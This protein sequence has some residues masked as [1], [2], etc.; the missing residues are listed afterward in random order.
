MTRDVSGTSD[1]TGGLGQ[2]TRWAPSF[3]IRVAGFAAAVAAAALLIISIDTS[4][5]NRQAQ[6][7]QEF[8]AIKAE[9]FYLAANFRVGLRQIRATWLDFYFTGDPSDREA[10][11]REALRLQQ[12]LRS[13]ER[14][15]LAPGEQGKF[16]RLEAAYGEFMARL[17]R[18]MQKSGPKPGREGFAAA[19]EQLRVESQSLLKLCD[20][21]V[22]TE[23][24][25][26]N[27]FLGDSDRT[28]VSL[29]RLLML[30]LLLL[31]ASAVSL[32][33]VAYRGM[34]A[35]LRAQLDES[36]AIIERQEKLASLGTLGAGVAHEIRNPLQ[37]IKFRLFSLKNSLPSAFGDNEDARVITQEIDRLDRIVKDFLQFARPSEPDLVRVPAERILQ[38]V[39]D[40][41]SSQLEKMAIQSRMAIAESAWVQADPQQI[42][43]VLINLVQNAADRLGGWLHRDACLVAGHTMRGERRRQSRERQA[44]EMNVLQNHSE[45]DFSPVA[46]LLDEAINELGE[47][48]RTAILLRFFEQQDFRAV[49]QALGSSED[50]ARMR[51]TRQCTPQVRSRSRWSRGIFSSRTFTQPWGA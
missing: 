33:I 4:I 45:A 10:F 9:K 32:A 12:W 42:K 40:L 31:I 48:N 24:V 7:R 46:P 11:H 43:Q 49:G 26:F 25:E 23:H 47:A 38:E 51:V 6:L 30:S 27:R 29:Q 37:A 50:A 16:Q 19:Y 15:F 22:S 17:D 14:E 3:T 44:V 34:I 21:L 1:A 41:M 2:T 13:G 8:E 39:H 18:L 36:R 20:E 28:L 5:W 35:P